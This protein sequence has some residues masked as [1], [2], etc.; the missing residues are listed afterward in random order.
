MGAQFIHGQ[1][2]NPVF[3]ILNA[4]NEIDYQTVCKYF[5]IKICIK[6]HNN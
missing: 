2:G 6:F 4:R 1:V 5:L 3:N